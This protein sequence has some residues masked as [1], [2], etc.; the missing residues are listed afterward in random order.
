[1]NN[2]K[3]NKDSD[4]GHCIL[5]K[6]H[7]E[8]HETA[9]GIR[10]GLE[11]EGRKPLAVVTGACGMDGSTL[12]DKLLAKG[13]TVIG[14]CRWNPT[15]VDENLKDAL[16]HENFKLET[17]DITEKEYITRIIRDYQPDYF[18]NMAAISLVPESFKIPI[19]VFETNCLAVLYMLEAIRTYSPDTRFYQA[20][21][22]E[23]IGDNSESLQNT[24]SKMSPNSPY[25][26]AKLASYHLVRSYRN[27][28]G[29]FA[30]NGMLWNHEGPRRGP[31][32]VT[33]KIT[34]HVA[35]NI[36]KVLQIGNL[37]S[38][39]DWGLSSDFCDAMILIMEADEADD[40][41]VNTGETHSIRELVEE[42]YSARNIYIKWTGKGADEKGYCTKT[43]KLLVE[44]NK[45]FYR[46][47]EV[48]YLNGD[49]SKIREKLGWIPTTK[50]K[51]LVKLMVE[52]DLQ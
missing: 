34:L 52:S 37:E 19:R 39:R 36:N 44:V 40:F 29:I 45:D 51:E 49:N 30:V 43:D 47:I 9:D 4:C 42:A 38:C 16:A 13:Y 14:L 11:Y 25:A 26:I 10:Y 32:F 21:T 7:T 8:N 6:G 20:S 28:Y 35:K 46:P 18:Y 12:S 3:C 24:D 17:G 31:I 15:G 27:V 50:F 2:K 1:M 41:A 5:E 22:S 33:R 23:Q 48:P